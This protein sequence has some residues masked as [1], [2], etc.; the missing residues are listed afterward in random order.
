[1]TSHAVV[2]FALKPFVE[3]SVQLA[4]GCFCSRIIPQVC[5]LPAVGSDVEVLNEIDRV[6]VDSTLLRL[7]P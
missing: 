4:L 3:D 1:M 5:H 2:A 6:K 7:V